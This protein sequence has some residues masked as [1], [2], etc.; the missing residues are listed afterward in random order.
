MSA[1]IER[2][3]M[4]FPESARLV[5]G[6]NPLQE[7]VCQ[8]RFP[9]ILEIKTSEPA[10][11]QK[12]LK[13]GYPLYNREEMAGLPAEIRAAVPADISDILA[14]LPIGRRGEDGVHKFSTE[15]SGR[16]ISLAPEFLAVTESEY[17]RWEQFRSEIELAREAL[18]KEYEPAFYSRIGLRYIDIID[19]EE[20]DLGD[21]PW[22]DLI[23]PPTIGMLGASEVSPKVQ[24]INSVVLVELGDDLVPGGRVRVRHGLMK[25][26]NAHDV[27]RVD[28]D[29]FTGER[30]NASDVVGILDVFNKVA[31]NLFRWTITDTLQRALRPKPV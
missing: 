26:E 14:R 29:F 22:S 11:F 18:E 27:Y 5:F 25:L 9:T 7:V 12:R 21:T 2:D 23:E 13:P 30:S 16:T 6:L 20:L 15:N 1:I 3:G 4:P 8:L 17:G 31:G 10:S 28:A 24:E 19:R